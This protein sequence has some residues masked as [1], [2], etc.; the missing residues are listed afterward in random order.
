[1]RQKPVAPTAFT[2]KDGEDVEKGEIRVVK[3]WRY[4]KIKQQ[5]KHNRF[6]RSIE[7][8][9]PESCIPERWAGRG[10]QFLEKISAQIAKFCKV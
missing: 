4:G 10:P 3:R 8:L 7:S 1:M 9:E 2:R 6:F 5:N